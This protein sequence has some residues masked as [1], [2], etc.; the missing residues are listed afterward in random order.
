MKTPLML[1]HGWGFSSRIW[2]PLIKQLHNEWP[3]PVLAVDLPGFGSAYHEPCA[4]LEDALAYILQQLPAQSVLCGWSLGGM[5]ATQIAAR[6]PARVTGLVTIASNL[7]F[8]GSAGW[9][10]MPAADYQQF[11]ERFS[12]QPEKTWRRFLSL[13]T[14]GEAMAERHSTTLD[15][16]AD[17]HDMDIDTAT[18]LLQVLG[19]IDNRE[20]FATLQMPGI[21]CLGELDAITP[22]A[23]AE[24]LRERNPRQPVYVLPAASHALCLTRSEDIARH[25]RR[26]A[27]RL[28]AATPA[29]PAPTT[30]VTTTAPDIPR[31]SIARAFSN[32]AAHYDS[33][34]HLQRTIGETMLA[35]IAPSACALAADIGCGTGFITRH[36]QAFA[37][38][39]LAVDIAPGM[40][41]AVRERCGDGVQLV[42]A[43][44]GQLPFVDA[45][46]DVLTS[47]LALQW[48]D[49][50]A[51]VFHEWHRVLREGGELHFSTFL[52]GTLRELQ[53][54]W[55]A[56]DSHVHVNP[57]VDADTLLDALHAAG[58]T[59]ISA[60][61]A[62][63][64][65]HFSDIR[66]LA[67]ALKTIG[68]HNMNAD[69]PR[70]LTGK[71]RWQQLQAAYDGFRTRDGLPATYEVL[72]VSAC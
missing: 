10:G 25:L 18:H 30:A 54:A 70:G 33:A 71:Q 28:A 26:F 1:L 40:L 29:T 51:R 11:C 12:L 23:I 31:R 56:V 35:N 21:H 22:A 67:Q 45:C 57:F 39:A 47:N 43:D 46:V 58:F 72:H 55:R 49:N 69:R 3:G 8:T 24:P 61:H 66:Q 16:L 62:T 60:Q 53:Q 59:S 7:H 15:M 2:Q 14:R 64:V 36:L 20:V 63:Q 27:D 5:L 37:D 42:Q 32:A 17:F 4:S 52:P 19:E 44:M 6:W 9:P 38:Q 68:A 50:P 41:Q 65:C 13:Q 34:A 48:S